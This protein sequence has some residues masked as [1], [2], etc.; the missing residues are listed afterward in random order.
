MRLTVQ[1]AIESDVGEREVIEDVATLT[2]GALQVEGLGLTIAEAKAMLHGV[3]QVLVT[4]QAAEALAAHAHCPACG[5]RHSQK[6]QHTPVVRT[7]FGTL[8]LPSPRLYHCLC[9]PQK[10]RSF[11]PLAEVLPERTMPELAYLES[12]FAA[13]ISYGV[14]VS[15]LAEVLPLGANRTSPSTTSA[16]PWQRKGT[17]EARWPSP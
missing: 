8:H 12:K 1:V 9:R 4:H 15:L 10:H 7:L 3:Q 6:G 5:G 17:R 14:T 11:S 13:L 16:G 2:R